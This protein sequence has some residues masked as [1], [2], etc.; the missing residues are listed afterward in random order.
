MAKPTNVRGDDISPE[1]LGRAMLNDN[2]LPFSEAVRVGEVLY[3]SGQIGVANDGTLA[4]GIEAQ[5]WQAMENVGAVLARAGL[6]YGDIFHCTAF[7][8]DMSDWPA[9]NEVYLRYFTGD[10]LP[11]RSAFG[12]KGLGLGALLELE[13]KAYA[14]KK[15]PHRSTKRDRFR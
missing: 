13:C 2:P 7:L 15:Q 10:K 3:L 12:V 11:A 14:G 9:F 5:T 8:S 4:D 6:A 1:F